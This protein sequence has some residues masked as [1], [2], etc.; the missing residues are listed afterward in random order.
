MATVDLREITRLE[1]EKLITV[2]A[3]PEI[4]LYIA[5]YTPQVQF[6]K[7]W[8]RSPLL[9]LCRGLIFA[10][11]SGIIKARPFEKFFNYGEY[12]GP[13]PEGPY[14]VTEKM[15]GSLGILYWVHGDP[16]IA[17]RGSFESEQAVEGT[18]I[19]RE[20]YGLIAETVW[21]PVRTYLFEIIYPENR[22][23]VN[24][25]DRRDLVLLGVVDNETGLTI[26]WT[27]EAREQCV[28]P[29]PRQYDAPLEVLKRMDVDN[30]EGFVVHWP[31]ENFRL[32]VKLDEYLRLHKILTGVS[33][34]TIWQALKNGDNIDAWIENVPDEFADFIERTVKALNEEFYRKSSA[35]QRVYDGIMERFEGFAYP[36]RKQ[37]AMEATKYA[38]RDI[39]FLMFDERPW[40]DR[41]WTRIYPPA[42]TPTFKV[43]M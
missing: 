3:H 21:Q 29:L 12:D 28:F 22:I 32:K 10:G 40:A 25:G 18:R 27:E 31:K 19:L 24:Y 33:A 8:G 13:L 26:P 9:P 11:G 7:L 5:N 36:D 15:D 37:F 43:E 6:D 1:G 30:F 20:K 35:A 38:C 17:T 16:R 14:E 34:R 42:D 41:I 39:L 23:V 4:D 2:R